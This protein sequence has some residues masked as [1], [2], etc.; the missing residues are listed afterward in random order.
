VRPRLRRA[1]LWTCLALGVG[2]VAA[3]AWALFWTFY[4]PRVP[5][6]APVVVT[7]PAPAGDGEITVVLGGDFAPTDAA[8]HLIEQHG[9]RYPYEATADLLQGA[10]VAFAN[11]EAPVTDSHDAFPL[12]KKYIYKVAPAA[13]PAW[14]WLGLDVVSLA[15]NHV[16][17]YRDRGVVDTVRHLDAAGIA[18]VGAGADETAARR[19]VIVDVGGTRIGFLAYLEESVEYNLYQRSYAV[20][21]RVGAAKLDGRDLAEDVARLRPLVDVL[22]VSVHWGENYQPVT[23]EQEA[24]AR[25]MAA[26]GVDVVAGHHPHDVQPVEIVGGTVVLYSLGNYAWGAPGRASLR[27]GLLARVRITPRHGDIPGR[28]AAV[29]LVPIVTQNRIVRFQPRRLAAG[30]EG[31]LAPFLAGTRARGIQAAWDGE[32]VRVSVP[33]RSR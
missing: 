19:P 24:L 25:R 20:G 8:S 4:N 7:R 15:K 10:D 21:D 16:N 28:V 13:L 14:Q 6:A 2:L 22:V 29:E 3:S 17:D 31:F 5:L 9:W 23:G 32:V 30:E 1:L 11:L 26:L 18:H 27:I 33:A 12:Y